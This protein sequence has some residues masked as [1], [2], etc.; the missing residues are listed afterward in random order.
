[1]IVKTD[2]RHRALRALREK[3]RADA[4]CALNSLLDSVKRIETEREVNRARMTEVS[5]GLSDSPSRGVTSGGRMT[6]A[7]ENRKV[8]QAALMR[9]QGVDAQLARDAARAAAEVDAAKQRVA[10]AQKA[11]SALDGKER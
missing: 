3:E 1:M 9:H 2:G 11:L 5:A 8:L 10:Q 4:L 7:L 6:R